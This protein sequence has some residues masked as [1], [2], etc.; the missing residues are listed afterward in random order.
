MFRAIRRRVHV[1]PATVIASFALVFAMAGGAY[2]AKR[3][4]ITSTKQ[5]SPSVLKSLQGKAGANGA[6]G[7]QGPAGPA[8]AAGAAGAKGETGA[9]GADG[10]NGANGVSV[11]SSVEPAGVNCKAGGSKFVGASGTTYACNGEKGKEGTFGGQTL[12]TGKTL[13]GTYAAEAYSEVGVPTAGFGK[14]ATGVSFALP[15]ESEPA[16][17]YI[18]VGETP[19]AGCTGTVQEPGA[20]EGNLC[21]FGENEENTFL[22]AVGV[23]L[24]GSHTATI[25]FEVVG[26]AGAKGN[27]FL[28]GT[29]AV[30]G[31]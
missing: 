19:P 16:I 21:V 14:A 28:S 13:K 25:G 6:N 10:T 24:R 5:I 1:S 20:A 27:I 7:A 22:G 2:A 23:N 4:V 17:H 31:S 30:T 18:K 12:P 29:W 11:A 26:L 15:L 3:Y 9:A 8:G